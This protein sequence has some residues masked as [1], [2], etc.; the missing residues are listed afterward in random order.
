MIDFER[1][2]PPRGRFSVLLPDLFPGGV[3]RPDP[4]L[5][6]LLLYRGGFFAGGC[7]IRPRKKAKASEE[8]EGDGVGGAG[9]R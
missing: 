8:E 1:L 7:Q 5:K 3:V 4:N 9:G 2:P 6:L